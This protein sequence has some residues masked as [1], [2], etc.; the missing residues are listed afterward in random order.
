MW[1]PKFMRDEKKGVESPIPTQVVSNEEIIPRPQ[2]QK[3]KHVE[4]LINEW[5][6]ENAR[7]LGM[8][9]R[10]F[11]RSSMGFATALLAMNHVHGNFWEVDPVEAFEPDAT[12]EKWPKGEYFVIDVQTHFTNS[13]DL[14]LERRTQILLET[15]QLLPRVVLDPFGR[16][17]VAEGERDFHPE[18]SSERDAR[19]LP[20]RGED[21]E[22]AR[23]L[24][25]SRPAREPIR[26]RRRARRCP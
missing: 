16:L 17:D 23:T 12:K 13:Y 19:S 4:H 6:A 24:R 3:Q 1:I 10:E 8:K 7:R 25:G 15:R 18:T 14:G 11:M 21:R 22:K 5:G 26:R 9:R 20:A 2:S